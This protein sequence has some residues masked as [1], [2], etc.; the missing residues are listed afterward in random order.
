MSYFFIQEKGAI[1]EQNI[2]QSLTIL[3]KFLTDIQNY[4]YDIALE[5]EF[6]LLLW[7]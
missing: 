1:L 5:T 4:Q 2:R 7:F 6:Y 3:Q